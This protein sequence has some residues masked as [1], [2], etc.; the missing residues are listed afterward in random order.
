MAGPGTCEVRTSCRRSTP[1]AKTA[2]PARGWLGS[3]WGCGPRLD[4]LLFPRTSRSIVPQTRR[5]LCTISTLPRPGALPPGPAGS[6]RGRWDS[7]WRLE[8]VSGKITHIPLCLLS[9]WKSSYLLPGYWAQ[10]GS[11]CLTVVNATT[12]SP[13]RQSL[14]VLCL[15]RP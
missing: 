1:A 5:H 11:G 6:V 2:R 4:T 8:E 12:Q 13:V 10:V 15:P 3:R 9:S 14:S 7:R